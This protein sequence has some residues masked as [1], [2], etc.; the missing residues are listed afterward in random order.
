MKRKRN[1]Q[2]YDPKCRELAEYFA[3]GNEPALT[4]EQL[5]DLSQDFQD[6][7]ESFLS[8]LESEGQS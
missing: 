8:L 4:D 5:D 2:L 3:A 7:A 6:A 1:N